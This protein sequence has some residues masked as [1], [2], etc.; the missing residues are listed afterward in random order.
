MP[1]ILIA[2]DS[3]FMRNMLKD[4]LVKEGHKDNLEA[5][6]GI[7]ALRILKS[8]KKPDLILLDIIMPNLGG[9]GVLRKMKKSDVSKRVIVVT[10]VGQEK[11]KEEAKKLG[12]ENYIVKPFREKEVVEMV[13]KILEA[14]E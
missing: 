11:M 3:Q 2:D 10:A 12:V 1:K 9:L 7:E 13:K 14:L 5:E 8:K 4:I 6:D